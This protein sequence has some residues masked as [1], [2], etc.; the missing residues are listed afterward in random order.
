MKVPFSTIGTQP[1]AVTYTLRGD[2]FEITIDGTLKRKGYGMAELDAVFTGVV[3]LEC[4]AC[5]EKYDDVIEEKVTL[6]LT[7]APYKTSEGQGGEQD[8]DII[9]FL[10]GIIDLDEIIISEV[11]ALKYDY[12][13]CKK[14]Q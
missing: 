13:K 5:G 2:D 6:K 10:D 12:H 11:N 4:D 3:S 1:K 14:C 8:Y 7:D 9:E